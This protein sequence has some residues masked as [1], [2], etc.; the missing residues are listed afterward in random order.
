MEYRQLPRGTEKLSTIGFGMGNIAGA[1]TELAIR[2]ALAGGVN[3][4]DLCCDN[5]EVFRVF[6]QAVAGC[7]DKVYTQMHF[8]AVYEN[9][10]Y[11]FSRDL[12]LIKRSFEKVLGAAGIGYSDFGYIHCIDEMSD[13]ESVMKKGG[14]F[15]YMRSLKA[16]GILRHLG[17][18]S[19]TPEVARRL[20]ATGEV[21]MFMFS[22]NAAYDYAKGEYS[23]GDIDERAALYREAEQAGIGISAMKPFAGGQLLTAELSPIGIKLSPVQCIHY[24]LDRPGVLACLPGATSAADVNDMLKYYKASAAERD[25]SVLSKA[26]PP[27]AAGRC[28]YCNHCA[29]CPAGIN[30]GLVNKYYDLAKISDRRAAG[31]YRQLSVKANACIGCGHCDSRC[32]FGV[33]QSARIKEIAE[34]F[35]K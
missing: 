30:I 20:I 22:I 1:G 26:T 12:D 15:D 19:H 6:G 33:I 4:F 29:P 8:G 35:G 9:D 7:R 5:V 21:D 14:L 32:P 27:G 3:L 11:G 16:Q 13:F 17:F 24:V 10:K 34:Y 25:Y 28:V 23:H 18:S 2:T 31:H